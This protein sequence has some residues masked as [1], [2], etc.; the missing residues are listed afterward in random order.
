MKNYE[1]WETEFL[2]HLRLQGE[3]DTIL[4]SSQDGKNDKEDNAQAYAELIQFLDNKSLLLVMREA[5]DD[6][7]GALTILRHNYK[8]QGKPRIINI[9]T[10]LTSLKKTNSESMTE[11]IMLC[12]S[13]MH[14]DST[15]RRR[16][17]D[18]ARTTSEDGS[19]TERQYLCILDEK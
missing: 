17:R 19:N 13:S 7:S 1:L 18:D 15:C 16:Q 10:K 4:V 9:C 8:G 5:T 14:R 11:Y 3:K 12:R 2:G 6:G